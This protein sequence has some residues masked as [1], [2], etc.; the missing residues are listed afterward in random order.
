MMLYM[1]K[2]PI[3]DEVEPAKTLDVQPTIHPAAR[4]SDSYIGAYT[5]IGANT[6]M[7]ETRFGDY[8]YTAG[9]VDIIYTEVGKFCSIASHIRINPG[10]HP[11]ERVT[12]HHMT[13]RR[14]MFGFGTSD[15]GE[16]FNWRRADHYNVGHDVWIGHAAIIMP[17]MC[18]GTGAVGAGAV[19]TKNVAPYTIVV[20]V[21]AK[22]IRQRFENH[23]V[24]ALL[25]IAWWNWPHE[26]LKSRFDDLLDVEAFA[27]K[28]Q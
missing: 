6:L 12:Q 22:P 15:D 23:V 2:F 8:S 11:M 28:Y 1:D 7:I 10:N 26:M 24:Q 18:I 9:D 14:K 25:E 16:F 17:G 19:V 21:P 27:T 3:S 4:I 5:E 13:Y 20:G